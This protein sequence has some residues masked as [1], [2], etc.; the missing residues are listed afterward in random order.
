[1]TWTIID[2]GKHQGKTL[3]EIV[4]KDPDWF[5]WAVEH[6]VFATPALKAE[7]ADICRKA[8][9]IRIPAA[10][11]SGSKVEYV[12]HPGVEKLADV[13]VVPADQTANDGV[14]SIYRDYFDLSMARKIAPYDK[15]GGKIMLRAIKLYVFG[16][17][18]AYLTQARCEAFFA[19]DSNFV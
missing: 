1:M 12:I 2:F 3:P 10:A 16:K 6:N 11:G 9:R 4:L 7:A 19:D 18:N 17:A 5:F 15:T 14:G 13:I 8:T